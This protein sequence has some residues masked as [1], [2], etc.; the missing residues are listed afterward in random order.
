MNKR[1]AVL[2][3]AVVPLAIVVAVV[4]T[5][6]DSSHRPAKLPVAAGGPG[7]DSAADETAAGDAK[8]APALYPNGG[9]A[10]DAGDGLPALDGRGVA[11]RLPASSVTDEKVRKLA[12]AL[13]LAADPVS[14]DGSLTVQDGDRVLSVYPQSGGSWSYF[15]TGGSAGVVASDVATAS[16]ACPPD[17]ECIE[18]DPGGGVGLESPAPERPADL[19]TQDEAKAV[20][21]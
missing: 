11:Y 2:V 15:R 20:A 12:A 10:Y 4:A 5:R 6:D 18:P 13:G 1:I 7:S 17:A 19:P 14:Q 21:L 9:V 16:P 3:A 8:A